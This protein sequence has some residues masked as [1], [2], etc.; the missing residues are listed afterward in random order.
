MEFGP[1][2]VYT[3]AVAAVPSIRYALGVAG[4]IAAA[5]IAYNLAN[6]DPRKATLA[7]LFVLAGMYLLMIFANATQLNL[8]LKGPATMII[9]AL[10]IMFIACLAMTLSAFAIGFPPG[11]AELVG[12]SPSK[13]RVQS[14]ESVSGPTQAGKSAASSAPTRTP[15][16]Q[17]FEYSNS[18]DDCAANSVQTVEY[19]LE[20]TAKAMN[21]S[22]PAVSSANCGSAFENARLLPARPNC[23]ALDARVKGCGYDHLP[24]GIKNCKGRGWLIGRLTVNGER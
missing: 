1:L 20:G 17:T 10:A 19:C 7:F 5:M 11:W 18:S 6:S 24:F 16:S 22:G 15:V 13:A 3:K 4:V 14:V 23:V 2:N 12:A 9:W 8:K 21:W